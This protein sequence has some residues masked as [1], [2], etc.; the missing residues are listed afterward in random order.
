MHRFAP[1]IWITILLVA[2]MASVSTAQAG[3]KC[4]FD[5]AKGRIVCKDSGGSRVRNPSRAVKATSSTGRTPR[6]PL[7]Y[8]K[9]GYDAG[10]GN[11]Y[12]WSRTPGGLDAW[13]PANDPAVI[14]ITTKLPI[15]PSRSAA[16]GASDPSTSAWSVF[17]SWNLA[18]P[19]PSVTPQD[20]GITGIPTHISATPPDIISHSETLPDGRRLEVRARAALLT[21][22]WG[23]G[24]SASFNPK[25]ADGYPSGSVAHIYE[26]KTCSSRYRAEHPSGNLCSRSG[27]DYSITASYTWRGE[28]NIGSGWVALGSLDRA[29]PTISYDVDEAR[30]VSTP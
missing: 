28:Y 19:A 26:L 17:R 3:Q 16:A 9:T 10:I 1:V 23:D 14:A 22:N 29:A 6:A 8:V 30:G 18:P 20:H 11:C 15:C 5:P 13:N 2:G 27:D 24:A 4:Q 7:R 21:V 25:T 12:N